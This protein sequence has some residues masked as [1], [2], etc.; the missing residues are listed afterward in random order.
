[1]NKMIN[2]IKKNISIQ[3]VTEKQKIL[4]GGSLTI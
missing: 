2:E 3:S 1:M 4:Y